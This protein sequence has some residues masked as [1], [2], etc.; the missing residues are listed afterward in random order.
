VVPIAAV[1][2]N[3]VHLLIQIA[4]LL[5][6]TVCFGLRPNRYWLW[7]PVIWVCTSRFCADWP[8]GSS[9]INV[10]I[11]DTRYVLESFNTV[12]FWLVP[13]FIPL[14][15]S[16]KIQERLPIQSGGRAG[17]GVRNILMDGTAPPASLIENLTIAA[18]VALGLGFLIFHRLKPGF[19]N[20]I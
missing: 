8:L 20:T 10:Y 19:T 14:P 2:S 17:D 5:L 11:R 15:L 18:S 9:A 1:L 12:L 13:I 7:M 6:L 4:L 3:C 16:G